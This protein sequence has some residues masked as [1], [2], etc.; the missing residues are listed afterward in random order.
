[1]NV[2]PRP[3]AIAQTLVG[4]VLGGLATIDR[5]RRD[6]VG[7]LTYH[8]ILTPGGSAPPGIASASAEGFQRQMEMLASAYHPIG[9]GELVSRADGGP[10][11]PRRSVLVTFDDGYHDTAS[12]AWPILR[13]LGIPAVLFVPTA[14]PDSG[15]RFWW[16]RL[17]AAIIDADGSA[18]WDSPIGPMPLANLDDRH[19]AYRR[20]RARVKELAN[21]EA[22]AFVARV[23]SDLGPRSDAGP[24]GS[25][26]PQGDV[27]DW[28]ELR[29]LAADGM[30]LAAHSRSHP[31]LTNVPAAEL[32]PEI[33]G[34]VDD[35][36]LRLD[37]L[38]TAAF[39]YPSGA[40]SASVRA[41]AARNGIRVAFTTDRGLNEVAHC[42][43]LALRRINV[44][45]RTDR[46]WLRAQ[47]GSR[48]GPWVATIA[49]R[50]GERRS[51]AG[52]SAA[53][54]LGRG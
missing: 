34:S 37:L 18:R 31:L 10:A 47:L 27:L 44:G 13:A 38:P 6:V 35:L 22:T 23:E 5:G 53:A 25:S 54:P 14:M 43:W 42:D 28:S 33:G 50:R 30:D 36:A 46:A 51:S 12:V 49:E 41:S 16:T 3:R 17:Y 29:A 39:A 40:H 21:D 24:R 32:D 11:L 48:T 52:T 4:R 7:V 26:T 15:Q 1:M 9:L 8:R 19:A 2:F 20:L 45:A